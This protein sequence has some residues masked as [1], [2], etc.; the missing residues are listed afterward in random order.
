[1]NK[2]E[3]A[4]RCVWVGV[5]V[6]SSHCKLDKVEAEWKNSAPELSNNK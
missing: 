4:Y 3:L 5:C 1:M 6:G 2:D